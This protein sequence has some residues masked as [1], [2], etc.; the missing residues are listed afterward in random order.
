[1][2]KHFGMLAATI[3][4]HKR[5]LDLVGSAMVSLDPN[6]GIYASTGAAARGRGSAGAAP[7]PALSFDRAL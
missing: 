5:L 2:R 7:S 3:A 1:M 4:A 6:S